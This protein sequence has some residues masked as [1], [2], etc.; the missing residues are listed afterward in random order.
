MRKIL[1]AL[2][3]PSQKPE[4]YL[5]QTDMA[6]K[7]G[8]PVYLLRSCRPHHGPGKRKYYL[9]SEVD[10]VRAH[11][12]SRV[13]SGKGSPAHERRRAAGYASRGELAKLCGVSTIT[14]DHHIRHGRIPAPTQTYH[15]TAGRY[16]LA[17]DAVKLARIYK[18]SIADWRGRRRAAGYL[19]RSELAVALGVSDFCLRYRLRAGKLPTPVAS[20]PGCLH[21]VYSPEIVKELVQTKTPAKWRGSLHGKNGALFRALPSKTLTAL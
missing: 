8:V 2:Q 18:N 20:Y 19:T 21:P 14:I 9:A 12:L 10:V 6:A 13:P 11:V 3:S 4:S 16:Y 5:S 15:E 1:R 7:L 17:S